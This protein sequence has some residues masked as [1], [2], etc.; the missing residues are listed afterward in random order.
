MA[1][2]HV[3]TVWKWNINLK[4]LYD[5]D[6]IIPIFVIMMRKDLRTNFHKT[7]SWKNRWQLSRSCRRMQFKNQKKQLL[8][9]FATL[10]QLISCPHANPEVGEDPA[11]DYKVKQET[12]RHAHNHTFSKSKSTFF[13][14]LVKESQFEN[15]VFLLWLMKFEKTK[16]SSP[17][18]W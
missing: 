12:H 5:G 17:G 16:L 11:T 18:L 1:E 7:V 9:S 15:R 8:L 13:F 3:W 6:Q 10:L 4:V 14:F 2:E